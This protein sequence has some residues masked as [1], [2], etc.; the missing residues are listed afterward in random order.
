M[1]IDQITK[2]KYLKYI[3]LGILELILLLGV[4]RLGM[5]VGFR[6]A[7][8]SFG[9]GE[10]YRQNFGEP[11]HGFPGGFMP[12]NGKDLIDAHGTG[13]TIL[14]TDSN[15]LVIKGNDNVEKNILMTDKTII[16]KQRDT[17]SIVDLKTG[18]D[19]MVIGSP[20]NKG[21]IEAK[22]IRVFNSQN[23]K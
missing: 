14:K 7:N 21:Q 19:I 22:F 17:I 4:F 16:R 5:V 13:G 8:F 20:N 2:S 11:P 3:L 12:P 23:S 18:D 10:N 1:N 6:K 15:V 9:W